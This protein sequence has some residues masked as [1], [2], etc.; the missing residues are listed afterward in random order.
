MNVQDTTGEAKVRPGYAKKDAGACSAE[1]RGAH[2]L[3]L[4]LERSFL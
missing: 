3:M 2:G 4:E 1:K